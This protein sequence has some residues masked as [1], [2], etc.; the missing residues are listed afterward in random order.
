MDLDCFNYVLSY[1]LETVMDCVESGHQSEQGPDL[2]CPRIGL[3]KNWFAQFDQDLVCPNGVNNMRNGI[4][5]SLVFY[6][7]F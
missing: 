5:E 2:V 7:S 3:P 1:R 4:S 6:I